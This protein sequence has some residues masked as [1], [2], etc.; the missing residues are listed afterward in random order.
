MPQS[1]REHEVIR[2]DCARF[3]SNYH[4]P[5]GVIY[6]DP[7]YTRDHYSR[8]YHVLETMCLRDE[9]EVTASNL[10]RSIPSRGVYRAARYQS[11]FCIKSK[12][13]QALECLLRGARRFGVPFVMSY[14]P[15][16]QGSH[17]RLMTIDGI[18]ESARQHYSRVEVSSVGKFWH[19][20]LNA[21]ENALLASEEAEVLVICRP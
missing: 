2:E 16:D 3:L 19:S 7:P 18:V 10:N 6:A 1:D 11:P 5:L 12:A 14:S 20:K 4:K 9:P 21:S 15:Y 13:P 8:Y 17:P